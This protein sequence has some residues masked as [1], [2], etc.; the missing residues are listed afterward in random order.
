[1]SSYKQKKQEELV[2]LKKQEAELSVWITDN[3]KQ[4]S[5]DE[6]MEKHQQRNRLR[7]KINACKDRLSDKHTKDEGIASI[8]IPTNQNNNFKL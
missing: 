3:I 2:V 7:H 5:T 6:F 4:A 8:I 1:M